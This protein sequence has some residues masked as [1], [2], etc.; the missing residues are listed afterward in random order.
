M[1][2]ERPTIEEKMARFAQGFPSTAKAPGVGLWNAKTLDRWAAETPSSHGGL[3]T[4][5][6]L[7]AVWDPNYAWRCGRFEVMEALRV[8]DSP[9]RL[10]FLAWVGDP[11]WA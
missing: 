8:W 4:A 3:V 10:A 9:H 7:L 5:R 2:M 6:F 1:T 11:W